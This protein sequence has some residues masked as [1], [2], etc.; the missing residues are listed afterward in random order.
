MSNSGLGTGP[1]RFAIGSP[2]LA[3][4]SI[5]AQPKARN[6]GTGIHDGLN[7]RESPETKTIR[8]I[9]NVATLTAA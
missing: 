6:C 7:G 4:N 2:G 5:A 3:P 8:L 1:Q 9:A